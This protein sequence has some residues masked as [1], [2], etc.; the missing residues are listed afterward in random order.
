MG[1]LH[2]TP[3]HPISSAFRPQTGALRDLSEQLLE[4]NLLPEISE[5]IPEG[6]ATKSVRKKLAKLLGKVRK[7]QD[8]QKNFQNPN[9]FQNDSVRK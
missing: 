1:H 2:P 8:H 3:Q 7:F 9:M 6:A 5:G 4:L